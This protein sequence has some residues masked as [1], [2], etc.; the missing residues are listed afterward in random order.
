MNDDIR[1]TKAAIQIVDAA[2][3][4][5]PLKFIEGVATFFG[6]EGNASRMEKLCAH[7][8]EEF[9]FEEILFAKN[10]VARVANRVSAMEPRIHRHE[11]TLE[12]IQKALQDS[13]RRTAKLQATLEEWQTR[14][15]H[16]G[17][18]PS[19]LVALFRAGFDVWRQSSDAKKRKLLGN[20]LRNAFD[21]KQYEEGLTLR[22]LGILS[23]LTYGDI[24]TLI[25]MGPNLEFRK[26]PYRFRSEN[27]PPVN[28]GLPDSLEHDHAVRLISRRLAIETDFGISDTRGR[29]IPTQLGLRLLA[30]VEAQAEAEEPVT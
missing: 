18:S 8:Y 22:L 27:M 29:C 19:D 21:P 9:V 20:A 13:D 7:E 23:E 6:L 25:D 14:L 28:M 10:N 30:L 16:L 17:A 26:Q 15:G 4:L 12:E 11:W 24:R 1:Q 3:S 2:S 5:S